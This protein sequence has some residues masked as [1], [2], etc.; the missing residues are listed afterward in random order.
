M[1]KFTDKN[2]SNEQISQLLETYV[3]SKN[4]AEREKAR[5]LIVIEMTPI[6]KRIARTI[7][8]RDYD[9][10]EDLTQAGFIGLLKAID[11]YSK[12]KNEFSQAKKF[13]IEEK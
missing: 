3:T 1:K 8:R 9:P 6:V 2:N 13:V 7:A 11:S 4:P 10:I 12:E 5:T